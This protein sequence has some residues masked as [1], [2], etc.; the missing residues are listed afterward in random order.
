M[1]GTL[2]RLSEQI[3]SGGELTGISDDAR[4]AILA[5]G[6]SVTLDAHVE[7]ASIAAPEDA[8]LILGQNRQAIQWLDITV[9]LTVNGTA[10][11]CVTQTAQQIGFSAYLPDGLNGALV[12][13]LRVHNGAVDIIPSTLEGSTLRFSSDLFS[14]FALVTPSMSVSPI[15][16]QDYTGQPV[17]PAVSV[18]S[19]GKTLAAGT[20]YTVSYRNNTMSG[21]ATAVVTGINTYAGLTAE[22]NFTILAPPASP[23]PT[24]APTEAPTSPLTGDSTPLALYGA[25]LAAGMGA[26]LLLLTGKRRAGR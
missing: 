4:Q 22:A 9:P 10:A 13:V 17:T 24:S 7:V 20:D 23:A 6:G 8:G 2:D 21:T 19:D 1:Q 16:D 25:V 12:S 3:R 15:A 14:L 26:L 5:A 11:G 18:T